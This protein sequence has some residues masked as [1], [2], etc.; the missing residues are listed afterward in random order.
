MTLEI[1]STLFVTAA[2]IQRRRTPFMFRDA[3]GDLQHLTIADGQ[4]LP[5]RARNTRTCTVW[6]FHT[7]DDLR[8]HLK[9][10]G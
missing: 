3:L 10:P 9:E 1:D 8:R 2:A 7:I 5:Y 4:P 6:K